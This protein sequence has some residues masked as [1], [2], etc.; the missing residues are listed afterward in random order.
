MRLHVHDERSLN[1][2]NR[3]KNQFS[4]IVIK[5]T[6]NGCIHCEEFKPV[7]KS[8]TRKLNNKKILLVN[9][10]QNMLG[11]ASLDKKFKRV[12]GY[13]TIKSFKKLKSGKFRVRTLGNRSQKRL[14]QFITK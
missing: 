4:K 10:N 6:M 7:W 2:F 1:R 11:H 3:L 13:P 14:E 12:N 9:F 8:S 5:Y